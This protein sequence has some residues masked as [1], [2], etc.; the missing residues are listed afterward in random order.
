MTD[1]SGCYLSTRASAH[2]SSFS[3]PLM[4]P[5]SPMLLSRFCKSMPPPH[6]TTEAQAAGKFR[7][8]ADNEDLA[9]RDGAADE[10]DVVI[11]VDED[12]AKDVNENEY[13]DEHTYYDADSGIIADEEELR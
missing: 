3:I 2:G 7:A 13:N 9:W 8:N 1:G 5:L 4:P 12:N 6:A 10:G 11:D